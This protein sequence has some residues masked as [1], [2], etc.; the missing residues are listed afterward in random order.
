[1]HRFQ[2]L[3]AVTEKAFTDWP[4]QRRDSSMGHLGNY[5]I[6]SSINGDS[7]PQSQNQT[8]SQNQNGCNDIYEYEYSQM[9]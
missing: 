8:Q 6:F 1:M 5:L 3:V 4:L 2:D 7:N 9:G